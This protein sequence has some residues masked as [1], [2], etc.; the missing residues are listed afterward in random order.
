MGTTQR[1]DAVEN[2]RRGEECLLTVP[3]SGPHAPFLA[4]ELAPAFPCLFDSHALLRSKLL[5][6]SEEAQ[7]R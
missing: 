4:A 6:V 3:N 5:D 1:M 2:D 7:S